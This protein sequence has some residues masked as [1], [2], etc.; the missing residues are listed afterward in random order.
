[1]S[2][3]LLLYVWDYNYS[4]WSMRAGIALRQI[5]GLVQR[6]AQQAALGPVITLVQALGGLRARVH[7]FVGDKA[8]WYEITDALPQFEKG[9][10]RR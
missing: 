1:M 8:P 9:L 10:P 4:S 7:V 2:S 5:D 3:E 6:L